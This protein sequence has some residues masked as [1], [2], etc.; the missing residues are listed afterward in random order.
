M[1][2]T[3][4]GLEPRCR[5]AWRTLAPTPSLA[6]ALA[7][8]LLPA[9]ATT[10]ADPLPADIDRAL[11]QHQIDPAD[12][13]LYVREVTQPQPRLAFNA[14]V[15]R[16][17]ASTI[18]LLTS[19]A[20]LGQL[21]PNFRWQT[22]AW[23]GGRLVDGRL[24][25]D[26]I[27]Q[28]GGDP[29]LRL[30][31]LWR[32]LWDLR[33]KGLKTIGGDLVIDNSA[34]A[35]PEAGRG[36]FDGKGSSGYN[37]LPV[38]FSVN[39]QL[40]QVQLQLDP[41]ARTLRAYLT[42]PVAHVDLRNELKVVQAPCLAR[43]HRVHVAVAGANP[44]DG[45][46]PAALTLQ[47]TF[48]AECKQDSVSGL[49]LDPLTQAGRATL[50][51]WEDAGSTLQG[52]LREGRKPKGAVLFHTQESAELPVVLRDINKW[53]NN[54][55]ARTLF[56][57]LGMER[58]GTPTTPA[59]GEAAVKEWLGEEG[60]DFPEL[61][62]RNGSGLSR[63]DRISAESMGR[64]LAWAWANPGMSDLMA[65]LPILGVDG[66]LYRRLKRD[67]A[68]GHGHLKTGTMAGATGLAGYV[69]DQ[70]GRRWVMVSL[71]NNPRLQTWRGKAV[72][73]SIVRWLYGEPTAPACPAGKGAKGTPC[74]EKV[75]V[76]GAR[77]QSPERGRKPGATASHI[78]RQR[79]P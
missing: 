26:L 37:A 41:E 6:L 18:K 22:R 60:L 74:P 47:G 23:L 20:A 19:I 2:P 31:D 77:V 32:F 58:F 29:S 75:L 12:L 38:A 57:T 11:R 79:N 34:F 76:A 54:L 65:S 39:E 70:D 25:G 68:R 53:S 16:V 5:T 8:A 64:L 52:R 30:Q 66:T 40:T 13:S 72:E 78:N 33:A 62:V 49:L 36:D 50:A 51:L 48:A 56:L 28:G 67:P 59:M 42:P 35:P 44:A 27:I 3:L 43:N 21:G 45:T 14:Q 10:A 61:V 63:E 1:N 7:L 4:P 9:A 69:D 17:P 55:I 46:A 71:I 24:D 73:E 15:P